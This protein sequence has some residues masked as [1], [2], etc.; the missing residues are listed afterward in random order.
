LRKA[1]SK[2]QLQNLSNEEGK[3]ESKGESQL[4]ENNSSIK[5]TEVKVGDEHDFH[6]SQ[7][8]QEL[9]SFINNEPI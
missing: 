2:R 3:E 6:Y 4:V 5:D 7:E 8:Y 1:Q 9:Q